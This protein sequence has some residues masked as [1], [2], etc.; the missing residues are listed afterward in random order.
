MNPI[1]Q[2]DY[3]DGELIHAGSEDETVS[4]H[5]RE[6]ETL[7]R[8]TTSVEMAG[9]LAPYLYGSP[10]RAFGTASWI[11]HETA[12]WQLQQFF[13]EEFVPLQGKSASKAVAVDASFLAILLGNRA[14]SISDLDSENTKVIIPTPALAQVLTHGPKVSQAELEQ[15]QKSARFQIRPFD[16]KAAIELAYLLGQNVTKNILKFDRQIV[17]IAKV[18]GAG[19]LYANDDEVV[20][21]AVECG[22]Q[23]TRF[24]D[25]RAG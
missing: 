1:N 16:D 15:I 12:G 7:H 23:V 8:C 22:L 14:T 17:A 25:L 9:K 5:L 10:I 6:E 3:L 20:K 19:V 2:P 18:Y 13:I 21:F 4:V 24:E 11:R